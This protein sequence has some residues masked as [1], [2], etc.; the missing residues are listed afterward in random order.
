MQCSVHWASRRPTGM[1][2]KASDLPGLL[3]L[4]CQPNSLSLCLLLRSFHTQC[5]T[6]HWDNCSGKSCSCISS[7]FLICVCYVLLGST[8]LPFHPSSQNHEAEARHSLHPFRSWAVL[9]RAG[10]SFSQLSN[11][12]GLWITCSEPLNVLNIVELYLLAGRRY[13]ALTIRVKYTIQMQ[14]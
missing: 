3:P 7:D 11:C 9:C 5:K 1:C 12:L 4:L 13:K 10:H 2:D 8:G 14:N 6:K